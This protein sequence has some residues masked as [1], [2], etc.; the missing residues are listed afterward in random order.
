MANSN[1]DCPS[2]AQVH[3]RLSEGPVIGA[4]EDGDLVFGIQETVA[5]APEDAPDAD[6]AVRGQLGGVQRA[7]ARGAEHL[8][9]RVVG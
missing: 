5:E 1:A 8:D 2:E 3:Q 4:L 7:H 9:A 6:H